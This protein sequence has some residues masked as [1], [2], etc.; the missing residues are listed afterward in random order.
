MSSLSISTG[1]VSGINYDDVIKALTARSEAVIARH[2]AKVTEYEGTKQ[3]IDIFQSQLVAMSINAATLK[4]KN[5]FGQLTINN[6]DT[7]QM[8]VRSTNAATAGTYVFQALQKSATQQVLSRGYASSTQTIGAGQITIARGG[9]VSTSTPS[10]LINN[11]SGINRGKIRISDRSGATAE[12]DLTKVVSM[13]DAIDAINNT[14][15]IAVDA[16]SVNGRI[17]LLDTSGSTTSNLTITEV[18]NGS[19]AQSLGIR[20]S[21]A[22]ST[23]TGDSIYQLDQNF[24]LDLLNDGLTFRGFTGATDLK[25]TTADGSTFEVNLDGVTT[26]KDVLDKINGATG[27]SGKV[28]ASLENDR[29]VLTDTTTGAGSLV[30]EDINNATITKVLGLDPAAT[31]GVLT[32]RKLIAGMNSVLLRNLNGGAGVTAGEISITDRTGKT[33]NLNLST[34]ES[35]DEVLY[36]INTATDTNGQRLSLKA[37]VNDVGT[38]IKIVDSSGSTTSNIQISDVTG[39]LAADLKITADVASNTVNSGSLNRRFLNEGSALADYAP[40][41][42]T[43]STGSFQIT[44]GAGNVGIITI[45]AKVQT[46]GDV[47]DRIN[48][49]STINIKA[50]LNKTGDG[51]ELIDE[52]GGTGKIKV[53]ELNGGT[54]AKDLRILGESKVNGSG[55]QAIISR[56]AIVVDVTS[57]DTLENVVT[58][59]KAQG[60]FANA[61]IIN[62]GSSFNANRLSISSALS[63]K[64]GNLMF[65]DTGLGIGF[66]TI[67]QGQDAV[68][69]LGGSDNSFLVSSQTNTFTNVVTGINIDVLKTGT[70][71]VEIT[72]SPKK[73]AIKEELTKFVENFNAVIDLTKELTKFDPETQERGILQGSSVVQRTMQRLDA[74]LFTQTGPATSTVRSL[75]GMGIKY[76]T[77]GQL[78]IDED[79]LDDLLESNYADLTTFFS[80]SATGFGKRLE[81]AVDSLTDTV[82]GTFILQ[83]NAIDTNINDINERVENLQALLESQK[84][85]I[86]NQLVAMDSAISSLN[87]QQESLTAILNSNNKN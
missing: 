86:L 85:R 84:T 61:S 18:N 87:N 16:T 12:V 55:Q 79:K 56:N 41:G 15:G 8:T 45:S 58:K 37:T 60:A 11:G 30:V 13:Q 51:F 6:P 3:G 28:T 31:G 67:V 1:L 65:D 74:L 17:V 38:G 77:E 34:A 48:A 29:F 82:D 68:L 19:T 7:S 69:R 33:T 21:V 43:V 63:G 72:L 54:T 81:D 32:G 22:S 24:T 75:V 47:I 83:K 14:S 10:E 9:A 76:N 46:I 49:N 80:E 57:T 62:D 66:S 4:S 78:E 59:I 50:Q 26:I 42:S 73:D 36:A 44:D 53:E 40:D 27:N 5:T 2:E 25:M 70:T 64:A 20:Q 35:L 23:L 39:T 71:P 52:S